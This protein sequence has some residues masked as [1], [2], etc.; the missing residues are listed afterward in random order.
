MDSNT[1]PASEA[2]ERIEK[3]S[4]PVSFKEYYQ[5]YCNYVNHD[6]T[7]RSQHEEITRLKAE[8]E[9]ERELRM[10]LVED[11]KN[12]TITEVLD[13]LPKYQNAFIL[14]NDY[15]YLKLDIS[16]KRTA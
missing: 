5:L 11:V 6:E 1:E 8:L 15:A 14:E 7:I 9:R 4:R 13:L 12:K 10:E 16:R 2:K 3:E